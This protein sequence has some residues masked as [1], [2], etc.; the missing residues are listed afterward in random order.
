M[1]QMSREYLLNTKPVRDLS[2]SVTALG[3]PFTDANTQSSFSSTRSTTTSS[4]GVFLFSNPSSSSSSSSESDSIRTSLKP[5]SSALCSKEEYRHEHA[6][7]SF[8]KLR[9]ARKIGSRTA[10]RS[11]VV[12]SF[13]FPFSPSRRGVATKTCHSTSCIP[14]C[15]V[16]DGKNGV[17]K[18]C[19]KNA[20]E[21]RAFWSRG[22]WAYYKKDVWERLHTR[23]GTSSTATLLLSE[24][25]H[26]SSGVSDFATLLGNEA[27]WASATT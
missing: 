17:R 5:L 20:A 21:K 1:Q 25:H 22:K 11:K 23:A 13:S 9:K 12:R 2:S 14:F 15:V 18:Q 24:A 3:S 7:P 10:S 16:N 26:P 6:T 4:T 8:S 27:H 19:L